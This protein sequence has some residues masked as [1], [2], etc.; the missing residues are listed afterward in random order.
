MITFS[1][2]W[3]VTGEK[4]E[5]F[6]TLSLE[7]VNNQWAYTAARKFQAGISSNKNHRVQ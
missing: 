4:K 1:S 5:L 3:Y 7:Q 2:P 6:V